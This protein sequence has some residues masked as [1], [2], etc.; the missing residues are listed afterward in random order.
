MKTLNLILTVAIISL[1]TNCFANGAKMS[2]TY[3]VGKS[4]TANF[5]TV[6]A[7]VAQLEK[8]G[9]EGPVTFV[10][11]NNAYDQATIISAIQKTSV[12][13]NVEFVNA[14]DANTATLNTTDSQTVASK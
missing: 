7:A 12:A 8:V 1:T 14:D 5:Q 10:I 13:N 11:D 4:A 3:T 6:A 2:G 9:S